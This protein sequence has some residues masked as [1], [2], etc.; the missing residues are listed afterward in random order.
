MHK[1]LTWTQPLD[2]PQEPKGLKHSNGCCHACHLGLDPSDLHTPDRPRG[3]TIRIVRHWDFDDQGW[4][5]LE[6]D[7]YHLDCF[8]CLRHQPRNAALSESSVPW[9]LVQSVLLALGF[10]GLAASLIRWILT[11]ACLP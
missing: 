9:A 7:D 11:N 4:A 6:F 2:P 10:F 1:R 8:N 3:A 5:P